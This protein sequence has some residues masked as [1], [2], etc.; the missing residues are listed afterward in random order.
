VK[1]FGVFS[2]AQVSQYLKYFVPKFMELESVFITTFRDSPNTWDLLS[3]GK[4]EDLD[5]SRKVPNVISNMQTKYSIH[6]FLGIQNLEYT[7]ISL[8]EK[9]LPFLSRSI[10][11]GNLTELRRLTFKS[12]VALRDLKNVS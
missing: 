10:Q 6:V 8:Y 12:E 5:L 11:N 9:L 3:G 4:P 1:K 2:H 7:G